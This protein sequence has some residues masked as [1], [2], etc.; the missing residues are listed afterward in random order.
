MPA[1]PAAVWASLH[2]PDTWLGIGPVERVWDPTLDQ[3]GH[4]TGF[5]WGTTAGP[6]KIEGTARADGI[7]PLTRYELALDAG[8]LKGS[9]TAALVDPGNG[10]TGLTVTLEVR[11][12]GGLASLFFPL[13]SEVLGNG[14]PHQ[15][16]AFASGLTG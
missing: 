1:A 13:I 12:T 2:E 14:L 9:L 8:E 3:S 16:D 5:R 11:S 7:E 6:R 10:T 15:V 4:L